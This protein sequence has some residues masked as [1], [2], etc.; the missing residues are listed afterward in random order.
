M[1]KIFFEIPAL[2]LRTK[3]CS[4]SF[5]TKLVVLYPILIYTTTYLLQFYP[6]S[7]TSFIIQKRPQNDD[8][9]YTSKTIF[10]KEI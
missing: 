4:I 8:S 3:K 6:C 9:M 5:K 2:F 10:S 1:T 7:F